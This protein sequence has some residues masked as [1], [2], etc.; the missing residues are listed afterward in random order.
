[1]DNKPEMQQLY[2]HEVDRVEPADDLI[3]NG[4]EN[5]LT[6]VIRF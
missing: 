5:L 2:S 6:E 3:E 4:E 1:M